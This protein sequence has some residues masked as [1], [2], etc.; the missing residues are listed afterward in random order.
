MKRPMPPEMA[1]CRETGMALMMA[2]R[3]L[4]TV[5]RM[6]IRPQMKTMASAC[7][8][9]KP[10][11]KTMVK[12][13]KAF[14]PMPGAWAKGTLA[15]RPIIRVPMTAARIVAMNTAF[16]SI[17]A[18]ERMLGLTNMMY[19]MVRKVV[20]PANNSVFTSVLFSRSL[21]KCSMSSS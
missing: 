7:C 8:Q 12:V 2:L 1:Y 17:P 13:K 5:I 20:S 18:R 3:S 19:A 11:R 21:K 10:I 14:S 9:V 15:T 16:L 4:V 6:L